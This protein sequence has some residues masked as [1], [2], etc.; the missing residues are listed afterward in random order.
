MRRPQLVAI[1]K[2]MSNWPDEETSEPLLLGA[3]VEKFLSFFTLA[4]G[5][6]LA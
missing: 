6:R 4:E 1:A 3:G 2:R 5:A